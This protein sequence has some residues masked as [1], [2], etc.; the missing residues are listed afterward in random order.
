M[1]RRFYELFIP[2]PNSGC[3]LWVGDSEDR[4]GRMYVHPRREK[5]HRISYTIHNG[6]IPKGLIIR[7]KCDTPFCVNPSHLV[8]GT[9][10]ENVRDCIDRGRFRDY[11]GVNNPR[12][13]FTLEQIETIKLDSRF[14][15]VIASEYGVSQSTIGRIKNNLVYFERK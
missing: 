4:Y 13:K 1:I 5:A 9:Q 7:H 15:Y 3:W 12:A 11:S 8:S 2:E 10:K 14:Q 6:E